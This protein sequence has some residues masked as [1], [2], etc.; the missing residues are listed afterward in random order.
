M[1]TWLANPLARGHLLGNGSPWNISKKPLTCWFWRVQERRRGPGPYQWV[2]IRLER[3]H[4]PPGPKQVSL[5]VT[6]CV[7][8][9]TATL[10]ELILGTVV[11]EQPSPLAGV[12]AA[13]D[14]RTG[15]AGGSPPEALDEVLS[16]VHT[17][18][19]L[20]HEIRLLPIAL[21]RHRLPPPAQ[22][23]QQES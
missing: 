15:T 21:R 6:V 12:D 5:T 16:H 22:Q 17:A 18:I 14:A 8:R 9:T 10:T 2:P 7:C 1:L 4:P 11:D 13:L 3:N 19:G 20:V 23:D